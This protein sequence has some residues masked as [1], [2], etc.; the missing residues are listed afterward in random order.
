MT[1]PNRS[2]SL[3][4]TRRW[5]ASFCLAAIAGWITVT[6]AAE[7]AQHWS[8][9]GEDGPEKWATLSADFD[10][11]SKGRNQSPIDLT[12]S[13]DADLPE[14]D[15]DYS[16][17][18]AADEVNNGHTILVSLNPGNFVSIEDRQYEAKQFHFHSPSEHSID[19]ISF[20]LEIHLVHTNQAG[21][22]AVLGIL[23]AEGDRNPT[24]DQLKSFRPPEL[25]P[26]TTPVDYNEFFT[27]RS[28][29]YT[30]NGSLT[31]P[32]CSE[33]VRWLVFKNP[34]IA[35]NEQIERFHDAMGSDT[36]RPVQPRN[37]RMI[38]E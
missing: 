3:P 26:R 10:M 7:E 19:G 9:S 20:P 15:F 11:C 36:N 32:P 35:S 4:G 16:N 29:Y 17:P 28:E 18:G 24:L 27:T 25:G 2:F 23:F 31:T 34:I 14:L 8:Y 12:G 6:A 1:E 37:A 13:I 33:G 5:I 22:L 30:Y 38:L 21:E